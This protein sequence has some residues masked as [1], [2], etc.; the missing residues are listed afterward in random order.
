M[1]PLDL[2]G[3]AF[4]FI[5]LI[6]IGYLSSRR[7]KT[8]DDFAVAGNRITWPILFATL[9]A[10][11][12]GGGA[13]MGRAGK[14]FTDGY[15][16][17]FVAASFPIATVLTG[18]YVAPKL[19]RYVGAHTVGDVMAHHYGAP[20]RLFTGLF[21]MIYCIGILGAQALAIGT[22]F[23]AILGVE[24]STGILLGMAVVL[25]YSTLGGM[26]AVIQTDVLQ[27]LMLA[28]FVPLTLLIGVQQVGG[29][30]ALIERLPEAHFSIMGDYSVGL[31]VSLFIA[32]LLGETLVPP[33]TQRAL[34]APDAR[35]AKWGYSLAGGFGFLFYFCTATIGL[36]ALVL[37]PDISPD[38][39]L[40]EL[41]RT[42]LP[43]G[44]TGLVL[45]AL[46][47]VVMSTADSY[48]NSSAVVFVRDIYQSFIDPD[49]DE[50]K[51]LWIERGV[52]LG[53]GIGAVL[54]ALYATSIID[55]LLLSYALWAPT[56]LI[57]FVA[58]VVWDLNCKRA[59]LAAML[60]GALV[61]IVW[62]WGPVDLQALTGLT[63]LIAGVLTNIV[64]FVGVYRLARVPIPGAALGEER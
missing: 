57:P 25:L 23:N 18:L 40:P 27:F 62:K 53:I 28:L 49:V 54:F 58:A 51:R 64:V 61:T 1:H 10:S 17:M 30:E 8:S 15:V 39:A 19:K 37:F 31:F 24:V 11:F 5:L 21:S 4:Y 29:A 59:A 34:A 36:V 41:V 3:L 35:N 32:Y 42:A 6:V 56:V 63:A 50:R 20:S 46:L 16:F 38:R 9:A 47:A 26:W 13:S 33:Y 22:V 48:L 14:S 60:A 2:A 55:A 12:L 52:N 44:I 45:A 43:V 7:V